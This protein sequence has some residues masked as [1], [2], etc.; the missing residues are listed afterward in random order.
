MPI[1]F[2]S[3]L[4]ENA[5]DFYQ[6]LVLYLGRVTGLSTEMVSGLT[7]EAQDA[8]VDEGGIQVVFTCGLPYVRKADHQPPLLSLLAAPV[9]ADPRYQNRPI[10]F[11]DF[12]VRTDSPYRSFADLGGATFACNERHSLSGYMLPLYHLLTLGEASGFFGQVLFSGSHAVSIDWVESGQA[13]TAAIDSVVLEMELARRPERAGALRV[14]ARLGPAPMPPVAAST[15]LSDRLRRQ[16]S[17]ALLQMHTDTQ[18]QAILKGGGV[19][20]FVSVEDRDYDPIR[21]MMRTLQEAGVT[22]LR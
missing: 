18:G 21:R 20:R 22:E 8:L 16:L 11:S 6:Q 1:R 19:Q 2:A 13:A 3:F 9:L 14:I 7:S 4:A 17:Q 10:Y 5:F 12:I 15:A